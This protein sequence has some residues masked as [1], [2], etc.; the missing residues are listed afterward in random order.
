MSK[1]VLTSCLLFI[2]STSFARRSN[3]I[4]ALLHDQ[5]FVAAFGVLPGAFTNEKVRIQI[6][7]SYVENLLRSA[8]VSHL[9]ALQY[10]NRRLVL[11]MLNTYWRT[12]I[13][14]VNADYPGERK[15]CFIDDKGNICAVG[16]L[17]AETKGWNLA[18]QI[19]QLHQY[20]LIMDMQEPV[21]EEWAGLYGLSLEECAMIQPMYEPSMT[22]QTVAAD[23]KTGYGVSSA[24]VGGGLLGLNISN[25]RG[26][27]KSMSWIGI[28]GGTAQVL[29]GA[30]NIRKPGIAS[31]ITAWG[32]PTTITYKAQNNLS[33]VNIA[34]GSAGIIT[35]AINLAVQRKN[36]NQ[37]N[38]FNLYSY[39]NYA[40]SVSLGFSLRRAI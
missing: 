40:N 12:G 25:F 39:P 33:Y 38:T 34:L 30:T 31:G 14:P 20:D 24:I 27:S 15:P 36:K 37:K 29:M 21:I 23:I 8:S 16:Y 26:G 17:V 3:E 28:I 32:G 10:R 19:N 22:A 18:S 9:T 5:S 6:H 1:L 35:N 2:V 13:F 11:D 7:L 4:N